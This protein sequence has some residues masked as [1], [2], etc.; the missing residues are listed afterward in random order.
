MLNIFIGILFFIQS[1]R[2]RFLFSTKSYINLSYPKIYQKLRKYYVADTLSIGNVVAF[3]KNLER[4]NFA[5]K[6]LF[7]T[8]FLQRSQLKNTNNTSIFLINSVSTSEVI[9]SRVFFF[10]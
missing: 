4:K 2:N 1:V 7:I 3:D 8:A 6:H 9:G 10:N 5:K